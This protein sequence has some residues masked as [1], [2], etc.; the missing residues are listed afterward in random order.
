MTGTDAHDGLDATHTMAF[1]TRRAR[2]T[3]SPARTLVAI[4][5]CHTVA[6][7]TKPP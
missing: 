3:W 6:A 1:P 5:R 2:A 7:R 4:Q